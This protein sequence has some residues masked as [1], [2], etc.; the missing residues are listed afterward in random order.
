[1]KCHHGNED[2]TPDCDCFVVDHFGAR[3]VDEGRPRPVR[4]L[5]GSRATA[6]RRSGL[7]VI[8]RPPHFYTPSLGRPSDKRER[9]G[10]KDSSH[11]YFAKRGVVEEFHANGRHVVARVFPSDFDAQLAEHDVLVAQYRQQL[12][13]AEA[14]RLEFLEMVVSHAKPVKVAEARAAAE[15]WKT[16]EAALKEA[17][18]RNRELEAMKPAMQALN[19]LLGDFVG[20]AVRR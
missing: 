7:R 8:D 3:A 11:D 15:A 12:K 1:M 13:D 19:G 18:D 10:W 14:D 5:V 20:K 2:G 6:D 9:I 16:S 17:E 4:Y